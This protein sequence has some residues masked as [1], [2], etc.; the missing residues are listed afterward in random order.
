MFGGL[1]TTAS[2]LGYVMRFLARDPAAR[3]WLGA[4]T[5]VPYTAV[6]EL[7]RRHGVV[8]DARLIMADCSFHGIRM[9]AGEQILLPTALHGLD[10][11]RF[12]DPLLVRFD[13]TNAARNGTFGS[14]IHRCVGTNLA[15]M[16]V[17]IVLEEWLKRIPEFSLAEDDPPVFAAGIAASVIRLPLTWST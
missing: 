8:S 5:S 4:Q 1:D 17:K 7:F 12:D 14:G 3:R 9:L 16:E 11:E 13:R 10:E 2:A 15:R 6:D